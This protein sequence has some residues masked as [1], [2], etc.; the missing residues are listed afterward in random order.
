MKSNLRCATALAVLAMLLCGGCNRASVSGP[1]EMRL[2]RDECGECGMLISEDR[3]SSA[4]IVEREG[5]RD[6]VLFDDIGCMLDYERE[7]LDGAAVVDR[8]VHDYSTRK[9]VRTETAVFLAAP[10]DRLVTP[11]SSGMVAFATRPAAE[12]VLRMHGG[13]LADYHEITA[14]RAE[15]D[16]RRRSPAAVRFDE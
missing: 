3:C 10:S 1:P 2:G 5:Q 13:V 14:V 4:M 16:R 12:A 6:Y 15:W 11:M 9:W 7:S 8:F